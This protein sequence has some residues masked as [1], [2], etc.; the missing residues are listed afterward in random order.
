MVY[1]IVEKIEN[2]KEAYIEGN[3]KSMCVLLEG[4]NYE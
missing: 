1:N 4:K 3:F 2:I